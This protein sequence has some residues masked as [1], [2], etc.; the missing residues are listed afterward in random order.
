MDPHVPARTRLGRLHDHLVRLTASTT[1][2]GMMML[3]LPLALEYVVRPGDTL[4]EIAVGHGTSVDRLVARNGLPR[5][6]DQVVA[7]QTLQIPAA[8]G[9]RAAERRPTP[10][11]SR[12][13]SPDARRIVRYTVR[14]GD[15][16]SALAV[17]FHAWTAEL[18]DRNGSVLRVGETIEIP[19][20]VAAE[21][22]ARRAP[23]TRKP[24]QRAG[25]RST[26]PAPR[27]AGS[28]KPA[29]SPSRA[30]VRR[31]I[32]RTAQ[33]HG[34]DPNLALAVSWQEAGWQM[35]HTS[36]AGAIG[37]MQV[38]PSTGRWMAGVVGR[39]L[40]LR[41]LQDNVTAGVVLLE[42][43][44]QQAP[45]RRAVAGYYQGLAGVRKHGMYRDTKRYV[46][47]VM[48]LKHRFD[49]GHYPA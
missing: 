16:P 19:V 1:A 44:E 42:V 20:V 18:I 10:Q 12:T 31:V 36:Y 5:S 21:R 49:Q 3:G 15:T 37:A 47:N 43:L 40:R 22:A 33:R 48:A 39:P 11:R 32:T 34:V 38:M 2:G 6:G 25:A 4:S 26:A 45:T 27:Q 41:D 7:G 14:P 29:S 17:R 8:H 23:A 24:A 46:A 9:R 28:R 35:H 13:V 30:T